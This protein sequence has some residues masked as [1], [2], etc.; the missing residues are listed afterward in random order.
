M[1]LPVYQFA[2]QNQEGY[3]LKRVAFFD[4]RALLFCPEFS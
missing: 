1:N 3:I 4:F 2:F